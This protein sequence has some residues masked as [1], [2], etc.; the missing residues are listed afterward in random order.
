MNNAGSKRGDAMSIIPIIF[1]LRAGR[2]SREK[3][4]RKVKS[5]VEVEIVN[6]TLEW[7]KEVPVEP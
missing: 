5:E 6:V 1:E 7:C 4:P 2:E 3:K